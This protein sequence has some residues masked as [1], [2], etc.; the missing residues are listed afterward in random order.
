MIESQACFRIRCQDFLPAPFSEVQLKKALRITLVK[1]PPTHLAVC[2]PLITS[3]FFVSSMGKEEN[4]KAEAVLDRSK[5]FQW[6]CA[7]DVECFK[8]LGLG[9]DLLST[10]LTTEQAEARFAQYGPNKLSEKERVTLLQRI[11]NQVANVLVG[12]LVFVAVV[13]AIRA[14]TADIS[15]DVV[16][17][18]IQVG[19]IVFVIT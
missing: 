10:G 11:W 13:S 18:T 4:N 8:E 12:I 2:V 6:H 3:V 16:T 19:L 9:E 5:L 1:I 7:T 17:N 15:E 14:A